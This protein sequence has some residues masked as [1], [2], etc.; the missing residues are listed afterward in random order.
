LSWRQVGNVRE[1]A[2]VNYEIVGIIEKAS[3]TTY[4]R[5]LDHVVAK[6]LTWAL[7]LR[8]RLKFRKVGPNPTGIPAVEDVLDTLKDRH[9]IGEMQVR[10]ARIRV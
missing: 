6:E 10:D 5:T 7:N 9:G 1:I 2:S 4:K 8:F 3:F